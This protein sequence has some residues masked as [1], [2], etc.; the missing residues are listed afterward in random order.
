MLSA[1]PWYY[2]GV[3]LTALI[4]FYEHRLVT[5]HDLSK[6]NAAFFTANGLVSIALFAFIAL[7]TVA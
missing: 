5:P 1:G 4:L 3:V 7:D 2:A 6:V